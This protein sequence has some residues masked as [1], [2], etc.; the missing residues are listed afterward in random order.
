MGSPFN[1][2]YDLKWFLHGQSCWSI[3]ARWR[4]WTRLF[5]GMQEEP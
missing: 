5:N 4:I 1:V 2:A 3:S